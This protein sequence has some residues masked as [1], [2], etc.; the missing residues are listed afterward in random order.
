MRKPAPRRVTSFDHARRRGVR[1]VRGAERVV[2]VDVAERGQLAREGVVVGLLLGVEAQVLQQQHLAGLQVV[3]PP[4]ATPSPTQSSARITSLAE[5]LAEPR[6]G[7]LQRASPASTLPSGRPGASARITRAPLLERVLDGGQRRADARVVRHLAR[8]LVER[9]V[10]VDADED[11]LAVD[12][13]AASMD[14]IIA[15]A[16]GPCPLQLAADEQLATSTMRL[17]KPHS[18][19][20]QENTLTNLPSPTTAVCVESKIEDVRVAVVVDRHRR[21][22]V[23]LEH[24]LERALGGRLEGRVDRL[25]DRG[26]LES[27][28]GEVDQRDVGRRHA[29]GDAVELAL[30]LRDAPRRSPWPRRSWSESCDRAAAR[31]RRRS[32]CGRSRMRWSLV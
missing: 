31:A 19:S 10:E 3:R 29:D 2:H 17:E 24:A 14:L 20:Y 26:L 27:A 15:S 8:L 32:L 6:A 18:L 16:G 4:C 30:Q 28:R 21:L 11:A 12:R 9:D 13:R 5:Q 7:R 23:V 22:V 25:L 1:A